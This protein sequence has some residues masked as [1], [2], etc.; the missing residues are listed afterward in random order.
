[1]PFLC[2][3][4]T[5][6]QAYHVCSIAVGVVGDLS[7]SIESKIQP[8]CNDIMTA[9]VKS[10]QN[11]DLHRSVKPPVLSCFG[12]I[13]LAIGADFEPYLQISMMMLMQASATPI[14][15]DDDELYEFVVQ[16]RES[17]LE[18]YTG[19]L[20]GLC[21]GGK[22]DLMSQYISAIMSF[23]ESISLEDNKDVNVLGKAV[24]LLGDIANLLGQSAKPFL[25][26]PF[27]YAL[28]AEVYTTGDDISKSTCNWARGVIQAAI[29]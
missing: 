29:A 27:V 18:A 13:A 25:S 4:L 23:V 19:I 14:P 10:L 26:K 9:L 24:G 16:L 15:D 2:A 21:D 8:F 11:Q 22:V 3:G 1:M 5:N 12:D 6:Y 17:V 28:L 7:R 20:Q